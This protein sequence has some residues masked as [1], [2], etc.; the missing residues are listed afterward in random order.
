MWC[1]L[2]V[3]GCVVGVEKISVTTFKSLSNIQL[4]VKLYEKSR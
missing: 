2:I 3:D 1:T 4:S